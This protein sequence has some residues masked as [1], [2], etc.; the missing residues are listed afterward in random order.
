M[1]QL[2]VMPR[3]FAILRGSHVI[4][5]LEST[6]QG[7]RCAEAERTGHFGYRHILVVA[8]HMPG[9]FE[10]MMVYICEHRHVAPLPDYS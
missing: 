9:S 4:F 7:S 5:G 8:E 1:R 3:Q 10:A 6:L 2:R